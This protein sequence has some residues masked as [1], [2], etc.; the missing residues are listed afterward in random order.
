MTRQ[1]MIF[2]ILAIFFTCTVVEYLEFL[3]IRTDQ[4]LL[5]KIF[6]ASSLL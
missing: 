3:W 4:T 6:F 2:T 5:P 1:K